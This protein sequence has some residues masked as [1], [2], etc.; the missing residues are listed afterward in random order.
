MNNPMFL[1]RRETGIC[2]FVCT[3]ESVLY[4]LVSFVPCSCLLSVS[5]ISACLFRGKRLIDRDQLLLF[6]AARTAIP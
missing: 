2:Y 1:R 3:R 5:V 6:R 4:S